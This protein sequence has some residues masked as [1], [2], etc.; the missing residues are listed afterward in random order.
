M[1]TTDGDYKLTPAYD[2]LNTTLHVESK[3]YDRTFNNRSN[4]RYC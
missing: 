2:L 3:F 4:F 1:Q